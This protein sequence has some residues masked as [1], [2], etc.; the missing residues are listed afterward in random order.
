[1]T[2][3]FDLRA[4]EYGVVYHPERPARLIG[5]E[6]YLRAQHPDWTWATP[7][8]AADEDILRA[9]SPEHLARLSWSIDFDTDT[10][11][12]PGIMDHARRAVGAALEVVERGADGQKML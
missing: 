3:F 1:M 9:H 12:C 5:S 10:P 11:A 8:P 7:C 6:R 2:L 4:T